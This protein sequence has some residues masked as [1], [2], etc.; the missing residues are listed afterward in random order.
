MMLVII[1]AA[2]VALRSIDFN[3]YKALVAGLTPL[4]TP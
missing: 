1:A 3:K 2:V 4:A